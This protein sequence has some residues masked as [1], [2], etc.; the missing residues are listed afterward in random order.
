M[1]ELAHHEYLR[2]QLGEQFPDVDEETLAD[3]VEGL[4]SLHDMLA[5]V[6]RSQWDDLVLAKALR[7]RIDEMQQRLRRL[8]HKVEK[9]KDLVAKVM[10]RAQ[11][12]KILEAD[13]TAF[14]R[15]APRPLIISDEAQIPQEYWKPQ[16]AKLDRKTLID[17]LKA[18]DQVPGATLG[19]G[20]MTIAVR[21]K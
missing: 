9:K 3:T 14:L 2:V 17:R 13:F 16:P 20:G 5:A 6:I 19:N 18:G 1:R 7:E 10:E 8:E 12:G 21:T 4:T 15:Q 11:I